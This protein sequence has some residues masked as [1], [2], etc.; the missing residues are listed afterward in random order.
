M[1]LLCESSHFAASLHP[2]EPDP[3]AHFTAHC[4]GEGTE[5][6]MLLIALLHQEGSC[7][8][9][10][11]TENMVNVNIHVQMMK[12]GNLEYYKNIFKTQIF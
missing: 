5:V 3:N 10:E 1:Y 11:D 2:L 12:L 9:N 6:V 8:K 7:L 4:W